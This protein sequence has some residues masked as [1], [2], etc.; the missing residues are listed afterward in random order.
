MK[1][2][3]FSDGQERFGPFSLEEL[4]NQ[5][6]SK[7]TLIW[8]EELDDWTKAGDLAELAPLF[9]LPT[10]SPPVNGPNIPSVPLSDPDVLDSSTEVKPKTWLVE[11][12][13]VTV[14]CCLPFGVAAIVNAAKVDSK[15]AAGDYVGAKKA[16]NEAK[17]WTL[18]GLVGGVIFIII[19]FAYFFFAVLGE[20]NNLDF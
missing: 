20:Y 3:Y 7:D 4:R 17:K 2:Y 14:L 5:S 18:V 19:Y 6:I 1:Q 16:S 10:M 11:S 8:Y 9:E 13:L 12:I 15:Y